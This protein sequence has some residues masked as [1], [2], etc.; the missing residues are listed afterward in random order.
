MKLKRIEITNMLGIEHLEI[1]PGAVTVIEG[2][3][4]SGKTS[5]LESIRAPF[6]GGNDESLL[7]SGANEGEVLLVT[8]D[9]TEFVGRWRRKDGKVSATFNVRL[10][11]CRNVSTPRKVF[12]SLIDQLSIDPLTILTCPPAKRAEYL[13]DIMAVDIP[14]E[15]LQAAAGRLVTLPKI[16]GGSGLDRLAAYEDALF[17]ERTGVNRAAKEARATVARLRTT[18]PPDGERAADDLPALRAIRAEIQEKRAEAEKAA[19]RDREEAEKSASRLREHA[20]KSIKSNE[21]SE[22]EAI[23]DD[24]ARRIKAIEE[25]RDAAMARVRSRAT[26]QTE[27]RAAEEREAC[28]A[29]SAKERE[30]LAEI[31]ATYDTTLAEQDAVI[32]RAEA[33]AEEYAR[34]EKTREIIADSE[35]EADRQEADSEELTKALGRLAALKSSALERLPVRGLEI[36]DRQVFIDG[37]PFDRA[38]RAR[39]IEVALKVAKLRA[40]K[41]GLIVI[42]NA[43]ALDPETFSA[44]E[45]AAAATGLQFVVGRVTGG[46]FAVRTLPGPAKAEAA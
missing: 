35:R 27:A 42:D 12:D 11:D 2:R 21:A 29:A 32:T 13:T 34:S 43:E 26:E 18:L 45:Q 40:G 20:V 4:A 19:A 1:E 7:R 41:L 31:R 37:V 44:F 46:D 38:N 6:R 25:E 28:A 8:E 15:E 16:I 36:R 17:N 30:A 3:N 5:V 24:A 23:R 22:L 39:Q 10:P 33:A 14:E 9:G